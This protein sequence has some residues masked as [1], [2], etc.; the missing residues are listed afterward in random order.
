M[1]GTGVLYGPDCSNFQGHPDWA[2]VAAT[3]A[4]YKIGGYKVSEGRTYQDPAH[5]YNRAAVPAAGLI[6]L[7]YHFLFYDASYAGRPD[8]FAAQAAWFCSLVDP[9][10]LHVL[11]V[12]AAAPAGK[13]DVK[14]WVAEYRRHFPSHPLGLY[15]NH[16]LW[17]NRSGIQYDPTMFDYL[18]HAGIGDG[19]YTPATGSIQQEWA[20]T[21]GLHNSFAG[22]GFDTC[23]L[24]QITDHAAVPGVSGTCDGNV[25]Q[26]SADDLR[27]LT[28]TGD[29]MSQADVDAILKGV[30]EIVAGAA[31]P[32]DAQIIGKIGNPDRRSVYTALGDMWKWAQSTDAT[33]RDDPSAEQVA[34]AVAPFIADALT[35]DRPLLVDAL[36]AKLAEGLHVEGVDYDRVKALLA[37]GLDA[38][39]ANLRITSE[40]PVS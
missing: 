15:A 26:G 35:A 1:I 23:R 22:R 33:V 36:A 10:A 16:S 11:D 20:A 39:V 14:A 2:K 32:L 18:W 8:L 6:P 37:E 5:Q 9:R 3:G 29:D 21:S 27:A 17:A 28:T 19:Y 24:W 13:M 30:R 40:P 34:E 38:H 12:E 25:F 31:N 7:A 4:T